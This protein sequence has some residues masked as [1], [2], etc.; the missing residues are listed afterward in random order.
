MQPCGRLTHTIIWLYGPALSFSLVPHSQL[1]LQNNLIP[2][3]HST[4]LLLCRLDV[5]HQG[6]VSHHCISLSSRYSVVMFIL[7][8]IMKNAFLQ[9]NAHQHFTDDLNIL[10]SCS[11][12]LR[13]M[14]PSTI[15]CL[16]VWVPG[17]KGFGKAFVHLH[18]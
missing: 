18:S 14:V 17:S 11:G 12:H 2:L 13:F 7:K 1:W 10:P 4:V 16:S 6:T 5:L 9:M 3:A 15:F 8:G